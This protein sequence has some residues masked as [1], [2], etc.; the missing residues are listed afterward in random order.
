MVREREYKRLTRG[1]R[2]IYNA[3]NKPNFPPTKDRWTTLNSMSFQSKAM[4]TI[5]VSTPNQEC[6]GC[7]LM[8]VGTAEKQRRESQQEGR[9]CTAARGWFALCIHN[10]RQ[11]SAVVQEP[12]IPGVT[13]G[14]LTWVVR[15]RVELNSWGTRMAL[16]RAHTS[17]KGTAPF[18]QITNNQISNS[19]V[20]Y[21]PNIK[22]PTTAS[23]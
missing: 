11:W 12:K 6:I 22:P 8:C 4:K 19:I 15:V 10:D 20:L 14:T 3:G 21:H 16:S 1:P 7:E 18:N 23:L 2:E 17:R 5:T 9:L 13:G